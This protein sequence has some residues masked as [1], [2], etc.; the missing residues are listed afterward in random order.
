MKMKKFIYAFASL[1]MLVSCGKDKTET[2]EKPTEGVLSFASFTI[3]CDE[4]V[5][6]RATA[7]GGNYS[8]FIYDSEGKLYK[9]L[10]YSEA[11]ASAKGISLPS[12]QYS[13]EA[14]SQSEDI[15][16]AAF[17]QPVYGASSEFEIVAGQTTK[18]N[19]LTCVLMQCK[20]TVS[21]NDDFLKS[22]T[23]DGC[24]TVTVTEGHPLDFE[25]T[26]SAGNASYNQN[27]GYFAINGNSTMEV[28][29]K[30]SI[31]G[32]SQKMTKVFTGITARQ[33]RQVK[34]VKKTDESGN[35]SFD[36]TINPYIED[37]NLD[38]QM[39]VSE[40]TIGDDPKAPKGDGGISLAFDYAG[41]CDSQ[42]TDMMAMKIP[43]VSER[44]MKLIFSV[45]VPNGIKKFLVNISSTSEAFTT[46]VA[47]ADATTLNLVNPSEASMIVFE[48]VPFPY[49]QALVGKTHLSLDLSASQEAI[50]MFPG[51]H[52]FSL[53]ITDNSGC[54]KCIPVKMIVE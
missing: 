22:V 49:G 14:R 53:D 24:A 54:K 8:I 45:D 34:F 9:S 1:L 11:K 16:T 2:T 29:F 12:G 10:T 3:D 40:K 42:F 38:N 25:M 5:Q 23:G 33:W 51:E 6:T 19:P 30:G 35:A 48:I 21:Y 27:A 46:A 32:K 44:K 43:P 47:A 7:A 4:T 17:E 13:L 52:T 31:D 28:T 37:E 50:I 18:V 39:Q 36:I 41:G 15:P 26:Y 20:V